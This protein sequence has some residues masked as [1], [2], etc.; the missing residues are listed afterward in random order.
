MAQ[1]KE[2]PKVEYRGRDPHDDEIGSDPEAGMPKYS[3]ISNDNSGK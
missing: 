3:S 1:E 2:A